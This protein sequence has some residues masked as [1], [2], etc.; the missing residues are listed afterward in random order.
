YAIIME[1]LRGE[2]LGD[3]LA[4]RGKLP[5]EEAL[6]LFL[7]IVSAIGHA[8]RASVIHR[9]LKPDN[10]FLSVEPDG[11]VIPKVLDFGVSKLE[12]ADALTREGVAMGTP[13]FMS[14]EQAKGA[15]RIDARSDVFSAGIL[16]YMML[17]GRNP[18]E[19]APTFDATI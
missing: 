11:H 3:M 4:K 2:T 5:T 12:R 14:P 19:D 17:S 18:F 16:F 6:D 7:P 10:I 13:C 1:L 15:P 8:H 9:D